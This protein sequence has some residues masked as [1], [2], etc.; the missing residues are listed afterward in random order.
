MSQQKKHSKITYVRNAIFILIAG[1]LGTA[2]V[3][4]VV[5]GSIQEIFI[6]EAI[7]LSQSYSQMLN[8]STSANKSVEESIEDRLS[9]VLKLSAKNEAVLLNN[10]EALDNTVSYTEL[11]VMNIFDENGVVIASSMPE[12]IGEVLAENH[13]INKFIQSDETIFFD[14]IRESKHTQNKL[15]HA[16]IKTDS[17]NIIQASVGY[18]HIANIME[19]FHPLYLLNTLKADIDVIDVQMIFDDSFDL[20]I[21]DQ[22]PEVK[23]S[24]FKA[25][26][27][28]SHE[29]I[30][31]INKENKRSILE[32]GVPVY[33]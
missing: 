10:Q 19:E 8:I 15:K 21:M 27:H 12:Y 30:Y 28:L 22:F 11:S 23:M 31:T 6:N 9:D 14:N 24:P 32:V 29:L 5:N 16:Y 4:R 18:N 2:L 7:N 1:F 17:N 25:K 33:H 3:T 26:A 20:V 13:P